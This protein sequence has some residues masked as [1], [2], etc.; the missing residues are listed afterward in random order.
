RDG[1]IGARLIDASNRIPKIVVLDERDTDQ[2]LEVLISKDFKPFEVRDRRQR[3]WC[4]SGAK[5]G[6][7]SYWRASVIGTNQAAAQAKDHCYG[8]YRYQLTTNNTKAPKP[9]SIGVVEYW[10]TGL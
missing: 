1:Q 5:L 4:H 2:L 9:W 7:D 8:K 3:L 6:R 10:S